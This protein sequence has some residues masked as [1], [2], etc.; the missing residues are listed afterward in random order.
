MS[1]NWQTHLDKGEVS[2]VPVDAASMVGGT[3]F[4]SKVY[5]PTLVVQGS[6]SITVDS[7]W[8]VLG[9]LDLNDP[10]SSPSVSMEFTI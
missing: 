8:S 6:V 7:Q 3:Y 1:L 4:C 5:F 9:A 10:G 2:I